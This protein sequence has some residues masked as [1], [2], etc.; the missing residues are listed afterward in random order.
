MEKEVVVLVHGF[1][2]NRSDMRYLEK[3]LQEHGFETCCVDLPTTFACFED[4]LK[5]LEWQLS[6]F[7]QQDKLHYVAHSMGGL[8]VRAYLA[9]CGHSK[10]G[11][12]VFIATPQQGTALAAI[13]HK[14]PLYSS[15]FKPIQSLLPCT[16]SE[17]AE[18]SIESPLGVVAGSRSMGVLGSL[19]LNEPNDGRVEVASAQSQDADEFLVVPFGHKD[20]HHQRLTLL[21]VVEFIRTGKFLA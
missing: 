9:A 15:V 14:F 2:K 12:C 16:G 11:H 6:H 17:N 18:T 21:N 19:F 10:T 5:S 1:F 3:G 8:L 7:T 13:A 4:C 20:I